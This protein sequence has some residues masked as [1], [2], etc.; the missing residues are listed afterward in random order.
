MGAASGDGLYATKFGEYEV[1]TCTVE[2]Q[3]SR[4]IL[5]GTTFYPVF[6]FLHHQT[7]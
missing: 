4:S 5:F 2:H 7:G 6:A 3:D 1:K